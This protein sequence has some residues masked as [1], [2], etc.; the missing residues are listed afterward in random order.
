MGYRSSVAYKIKFF[1]IDTMRLFVTEAKS[2]EEYKEALK[3][4]EQYIATQ[5]GLDINEEKLHIKFDVSGWKWYEGY[6]EVMAHEALLN[7]AKE[8]RD[9][10]EKEVE[11]AFARIGEEE[12]DIESY[13]SD[14]GYD[15]VWVSRQ[16]LFD[17]N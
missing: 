9:E 15:L 5:E 8:Y 3:D 1:D 12:G 17:D 14:N 4:V 7:L 6:P 13:A 10:A 2:K 16:I 11:Y